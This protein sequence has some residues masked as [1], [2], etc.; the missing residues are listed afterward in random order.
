MVRPA[1]IESVGLVLDVNAT[2]IYEKP[3]DLFT[4]Q[5]WQSIRQKN[6]LSPYI[7]G[8]YY[9]HNW[10]PMAVPPLA[11]PTPLGT[12]YV[13]P[14]P[15]IGTTRLPLHIPQALPEFAT[16]EATTPSCQGIA[17]FWHQSHDR[18]GAGA[19]QRS[20]DLFRT[21]M[22]AG[23]DRCHVV[24]GEAA[25][26]RRRAQRRVFDWR[27][28]SPDERPA[29]MPGRGSA[30][31]TASINSTARICGTGWSARIRRVRSNRRRS[32]PV[33]ASALRQAATDPVRGLIAVN[34]RL[35]RWGRS[36]TRSAARRDYGAHDD[37][38]GDPYDAN[39]HQ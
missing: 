3:I 1:S 6:L 11:T 30:F 26:I 32:C 29:P 20:A 19:W 25:S 31:R 34:N 16:P 21:A 36:S 18:A 37:D 39:H 27:M 35:C 28:V 22:Q 17:D 9:D 7:Q 5:R 8:I 12:I 15:S 23:R 38:V 13:W 24:P 33:P 4:D 14:I 2:P 10:A